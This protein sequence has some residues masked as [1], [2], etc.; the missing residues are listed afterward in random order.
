MDWVVVE[1]DVRSQDARSTK[2][3]IVINPASSSRPGG[4]DQR[5]QPKGHRVT[6]YKSNG[7]WSPLPAVA[8]AIGDRRAVVE[9]HSALN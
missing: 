9:L 7:S 5:H 4:K 1:A 2:F 8:Q 6:R 3:G